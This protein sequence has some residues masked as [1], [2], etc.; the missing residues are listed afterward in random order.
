MKNKGIPMQKATKT[1][2]VRLKDNN[3]DTHDIRIEAFEHN[4]IIIPEGYGEKT[5]QDGHGS[6]VMLDCYNGKLEMCLWNDINTEDPIIID[7][8]GAKENNRK[9]IS[10]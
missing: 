4:I 6:P 10:K 7:M 9:V 3:G 2:N 5:A 1:M 8:E